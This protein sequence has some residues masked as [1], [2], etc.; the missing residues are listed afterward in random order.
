MQCCD[1]NNKEK[2]DRLCFVLIFPV[3]FGSRFVKKIYL[4]NTEIIES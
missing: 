2:M 3:F 4:E 1:G